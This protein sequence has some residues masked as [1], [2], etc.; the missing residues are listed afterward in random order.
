MKIPDRINA[1]WMATLVD[2]QLVNAEAELHAVYRRQ[3]SAEKA[4]A[5]ARYMLLQGPADLV[6]A[7]QRW[8]LV[9]NETNHRGL[10]VRHRA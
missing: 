3:E 8:S 5:G 1:R 2:D 4:R 7:W 9:N 10:F 6:N